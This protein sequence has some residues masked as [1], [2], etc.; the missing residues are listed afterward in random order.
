MYKLV[1]CKLAQKEH[2]ESRRQ[3]AHVFHVPNQI[4]LA[5][6]FADL[7]ERFRLGLLMHEL[8]HIL[9]GPT[10]GEKAANDAILDYSG[11]TVHYGSF[12]YGPNLEYINKSDFFRARHT[13]AEYIV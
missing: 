8:G 3:Y 12:C 7:P 2:N 13:L 6:E 1:H 10:K 4:C 5:Y 11:V 9:A